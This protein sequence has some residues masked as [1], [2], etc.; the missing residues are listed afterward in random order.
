VKKSHQHKPLRGS[1]FGGGIYSTCN[2]GAALVQS[3][4]GWQEHPVNGRARVFYLKEH[5]AKYGSNPVGVK[6]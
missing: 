1:G 6:S 3:F 4:Q 5:V 2:C